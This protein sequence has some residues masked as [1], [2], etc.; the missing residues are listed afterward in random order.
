LEF[1]R[2]LFRSITTSKRYPGLPTEFDEVV[3]KALAKLPSERYRTAGELVE[4]LN[5][6]ITRLGNPPTAPLQISDGSKQYLVVAEMPTIPTNLPAMPTMPEGQR[7]SG[8]VKILH[9]QRAAKQPD[10]NHY[11]GRDNELRLLK[12][13]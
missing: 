7:D 3:M 8:T 1:R 12:Q 6:T 5:S 10:F 2:V 13:Q 11:V 4:R 9:A